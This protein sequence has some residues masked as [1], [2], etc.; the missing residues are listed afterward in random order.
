METPKTTVDYVLIGVIG[1][2]PIALV[3]QIVVY[4]ERFLRILFYSCMVNMKIP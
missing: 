1:F 3:V 2:I 4:V